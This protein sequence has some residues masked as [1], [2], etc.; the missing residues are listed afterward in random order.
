[1][2]KQA[3]NQRQDSRTTTVPRSIPQ[4]IQPSHSLVVNVGRGGAC[5]WLNDPP[6]ADQGL[7]LNFNCD[8]QDYALLSRIVWSRHCTPTSHRKSL[9]RVEG[10]QA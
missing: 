8:G 1:M 2:M 6:P 9:P 10:W 4:S 5:L 3:A 7:V